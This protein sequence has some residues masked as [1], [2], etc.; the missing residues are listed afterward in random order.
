MQLT[1]D[2]ALA[3]E[4]FKDFLD[5]DKQVFVL[6]GYAGTGKTTLLQMMIEYVRGLSLPRKAVLMAPTGRASRVLSHKTNYPAATIHRTIYEIDKGPQDIGGK[7]NFVAKNNVDSEDSIYF[8]D[9]ASMISDQPSDSD[10]VKFGS[11]CLLQDLLQYCCCRKIVFVGDRAQLPPVG[12]SFSPALDEDVLHEKYQLK[13][14]SAVLREVVRQAA[15]SGVYANSMIVRSAIEHDDYNEFGIEEGNGVLCIESLFDEYL[16]EVQSN[17]DMDAVMITYSNALA[18]CYN[19]QVHSTLFCQTTERLLPGDLLIIAR[20][21][22]AYNTELFNGT[23]VKVLACDSDGELVRRSVRFFTRNKDQSGKAI[24]KEV[25]ISFRN[26]TIEL[27]D[28]YALKCKILDSFLTDEKGTPDLE[29]TQALLVDFENRNPE[30]KR[31]TPEYLNAIKKDPYV[32]AVICKYGYAI[33]CHK[34]QGGEWR[35]VFVDMNRGT[36]T[37]NSD[38]FHWVYTAITRSSDKLWVANAPKFNLFSEMVVS[39]IVKGGNVEFYVP[40]SM[41]FLDYRFN[42]MA[43][44]CK[45]RGWVCQEDRSKQFQ[46]ILYITD[47][48]GDSCVIQLWYNKS[49]YSGNDKIVSASSTQFQEQVSFIIKKSIIETEWKYKGENPR[50]DKL[51]EWVCRKTTGLGMTIFNISRMQFLDRYYM[52]NGQDYEVVSFTYNGK[53]QYTQCALQSTSGSEDEPL[54]AFRDEILKSF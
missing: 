24:V 28:G 10:M 9:E 14:D 30:L 8:I 26:V 7:L 13:T 36:G 39:P 31:K 37:R 48:Q 32:N 46:H 34:A 17:V 45:Q 38:F 54:S 50:A 29:L 42:K 6:S 19:Q 1:N 35:K 41:G 53:M 16:A 23:I 25:Q 18:L 5:S 22:Y 12:Q 2:Q 3:L 43:S 11:G 49:G 15:Q 4:V 40:E 20:N 33:T 44:L 52:T 51:Y 21:N 47:A 27:D